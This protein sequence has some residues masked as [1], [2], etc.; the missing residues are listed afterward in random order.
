[1]ERRRLM[2]APAEGFGASMSRTVPWF[3]RLPRGAVAR[4][5]VIER[6]T[7]ELHRAR[8]VDPGDAMH[9]FGFK[10]DELAF[11]REVLTRHPRYWIYRTH[12]QRRC[13]DFEAVDMSSPDPSRRVVH[14]LELKRDEPVRVDRGAGLQLAQAAELGAALAIETAVV[15]E[16]APVARVIGD[17]RALAAWL[18]RA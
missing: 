15:P 4:R 8:R 5:D 13:G 11:A 18:G 9:A 14:V 1:M 10:C 16:G 3:L 2:V 7:R 6:L 12:Q 17:G